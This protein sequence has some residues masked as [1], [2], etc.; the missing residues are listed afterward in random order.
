MPVRGWSTD[1]ELA[2]DETLA[3]EDQRDTKIPNIAEPQPTPEPDGDVKARRP[4]LWIMGDWV[5]MERISID[6]N[7]ANRG[8]V[9]TGPS[10]VRIS[11]TN[12]V[13]VGYY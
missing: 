4:A 1:Q 11:G 8:T 5:R 13:N 9:V 3:P 2:A 12:E 10:T 7:S 6:F